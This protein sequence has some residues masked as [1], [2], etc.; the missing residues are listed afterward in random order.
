MNVLYIHTHDSG[1]MLSPYG[2]DAPT[3]NL[4]AFSADAA[5]F[6]QAYCAGPTCSPSR[7]AL[8]TGTYPHQNGMLGLAQRGFGLNDGS[9]HLAQF[10]GRNGYHTVLCGIQH[11][12]GWYLD[13]GGSEKLGY[14]EIL[15]APTEN[16]AKEDL[17]HWDEVNADRVCEWLDQAGDEPF[18]LSYG[19]HCT[20]R[21]YPIEV[22][23]VVDERFVHPPFPMDNNAQTRH[24]QAQFMTSAYYMDQNFGKVIGKLKEKG[25]MEKTVILF[26]TDHGVAL[27]YNK[28]NLRDTGIGVSLIM[29]VPDAKAN[30]H[31]VDSLVSHVDVIPTLCDLLHLEKPEYLE[32]H[33]F[34]EIFDDPSAEPVSEIYAEVN[35]HTSYE[36]MRCVRT[37]RYKYIRYYDESWMKTN[38]SNI[39]SSSSKDFYME[40]GLKE[41]VKDKEALY[42]CLY[43]PSERNNLIDDPK[44]ADIVKQLKTKLQQFQIKTEDPILDGELEI[45]PGYKVNRKECLNASSKNPEDYDPRGRWQ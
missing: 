11:E 22:C 28:C 34:A 26:T 15:T 33:S 20:H 43:D 31:V 10:L 30:G 21:P 39:D 7:A 35:F 32:G 3:D 42:D 12:S 41:Q 14:D 36:P 2:A 16:Y 38:C 4:K 27:P 40:N 1:R 5:V 18:F 23:E 24:D 29:R 9:K 25:L 44:Y 13:K 6:T 8:L 45:K 19:M 17:H 37:K